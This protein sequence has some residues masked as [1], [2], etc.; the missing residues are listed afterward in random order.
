METRDIVVKGARVHNLVGV[1]VTLPDRELICLTGVSGSGKSSLAFDTIYAEGQRRYVE[2][3]SAYARQFLGQME[4][5]DVDQISGLSPTISIEQKSAGRNPRSTVGTMTEIYDYLRV[6]FARVGAPHCASCGEPIGA[7]TRDGIV[8]R[9]LESYEGE[10]VLLLA[11]VVEGRKGEYQDLF[12]DLQRQGYIRVRVDGRVVLLTEV[13]ALERHIRHDVD[14]VVDRLAIKSETRPRLGEAVDGA[15][16]LSG[17]TLVIQSEGRDD[18]LVSV[19][20]SCPSCG[21]SASPPTPQ[22]FSFNSPQGMCAT[23][24]GLGTHVR[25]DESLVVPDPTLSVGQ[26]AIAPLGIP[27]NRWKMHYYEGVLGRHRADL[28]T[29]WAKIPTKGRRE[30]LYGVRGSIDLAWKRR[31]GSV[32]RHRGRFEGILPPLETRYAESGSTAV[33]R[34]LGAFMLEGPCGECEGSRLKAEARSVLLDGRSLPDV[35][36]M[37]IDEAR[38]FFDGLDLGEKQVTIAEDALKEIHARLTFLLDV[39]LDYLS[40]GRTAPT[41]SGGEAQR[42]RLA[43]QIG[44]GL[45]G[46]TYVLDEPSIGLHHRDNGRLLDAL[47]RLRDT[48]NRVVIVEHDEDTMRRADRILDFGPGPGHLGGKVVAEGGWRQIARTKS[49]ITG[50]YLSGRRQ[51]EIPRE[52][53][54]TKKVLTIRGACQNNLKNVTVGIPT[55]VLTCVTG[56]SGSGKSSLINDVLYSALAR[57]LNGAETRPGMYRRIDGMD[58]LDKVIEIDQQPIGR[59]PRSNPATYTGAFSP[60]RALFSELPESRVRGYKPGRFSFNVKG[61]RCEACQ[62]NGANLVEMD[63]LAD[64][65]VSCPVCEGRRFRRETLDAQFK[66]HSI[67]DVLEMEVEEACGLFRDIPAIHRVLSV[68]VD[69]GMG[70]VK[71]G[72]PAPTLSGGEAQRIKLAKELCR[73]NTGKTLYIL[74]EPTTG[75]HFADVQNL[76]NV[77]N[78]LVDLGNTVVVIEHNTDVIKMADWVIDLGPEGGEEGGDVVAVGPPESLVDVEGSHTGEALKH[79]LGPAKP[80]RGGSPQAR[81]KKVRGLSEIEIYGARE[82]NLRGVDAVIP[83]DKMTVISGVSGSGKSSLALDTVFAEGQRRY[84][85][86]LS[87]YARQFLGQMPKPKVDRVVGLSPAISIEQKAASKNPRSTVG[88]VTEVYDYL[89]ALYGLLAEVHC[90]N[91]GCEDARATAQSSSQIVDRLV[92]GGSGERVILLAP[93]RP[94]RGEDYETVISRAQRSGYRRGRLDGDL[95]EL[96]HPPEIDYRQTHQLEV[97]VDRV[98]LK[99]SARKRIGESVE[100]AL[101]MSGGVVVAAFPDRDTESRYSQH[102]SCPSCA[103]SFDL[104]TPQSFSFNNPEGWCPACEGLGTQRGMGQHTLIPD[105][106]RSVADGA[107]VPWGKPHGALLLMLQMVADSVGFSL[108]TA[109]S[110]LDDDAQEALLYGTG[111]VAYEATSGLSFKFKGLFPT[112]ETLVRLSTRFRRAMGEF[113]KD[114]PCPSC[115]G[116]R[117][118]SVSSAARLFGRPLQDLTET[119]IAEL[120]VWFDGLALSERENETAGEVMKEILNRLHFL[121]DVGLGYLTLGRRAPTLSGGEAQRIRLASQIGSGLTGVLYVLDEPT[122]GLHQRDNRRLLDALQRLRDLGN[123]LIVVEHDRDTLETADH[124]L[125]FG[126]GAGSQGGELVASGPPARLPVR[127]GSLTAQYL[128][129]KLSIDVPDRRIGNGKTIDVLGARQNNLKGI[130]VRFPLGTFVCVTG[131]SGSGKSSLINDVLYGALATKVNRVHRAWGDHDEVIGMDQV[132]KVIRID[133][134][135][136]GHSP[137]SNPCTY[138]KVFDRIRKFYSELPDAQV[139]GFKPGHFSFNNR[140]GR[141]D[142]CDGLGVLCVEMHFLPDVWVTCEACDGKRYNRDVLDV[143]YRGHSIAD[144]LDMTIAEASDLFANFP[145]VLRSLKTLVDVGLGYMKMGQASTTLSGGEAQRVKLSREL[146]RP[147]TRRTVYLL[148][149]PTTGLHFADIQKLLEV[150][151]RLVDAGNTVIVIEHNLDVIKTADWVVDLGPEGGAEGGSL[152]AVGT[153]EDLAEVEHS[154]TGRFLSEVLQA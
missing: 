60:I 51:I 119:P 10:R 82:N 139:R 9:I 138:V 120:R 59:T 6:L 94:D 79:A 85:E 48:G 46:V 68:L 63:F 84:V 58:L 89:R 145:G 62:G 105:P 135:P 35:T 14:V 36:G 30:L 143:A 116:T 33:R 7:Q 92:N 22:L 103:Q 26:G 78:R 86:S 106:S 117:L 100:K 31:N 40:L 2:S 136:I 8:D 146:A 126:P 38:V 69:V 144:V 56:V 98:G 52:R 49:S 83:R 87:A 131:V 67:A 128:K 28:N 80:I 150:L 77:L 127:G 114:V 141:C 29:P 122:I 101:D 17:G 90:P 41:L 4:K 54:T 20:Y 72:Q 65:W 13:P 70:Y 99:T 25:M 21:Q 32:Y 112:I 57:D 15:T 111:D 153:P 64:V 125:D 34:K 97:V 104:P 55:G 12:E 42:I 81:R 113:V 16:R 95:F 88:T 149:E 123:T 91:R 24:R 43:S 47:C 129:G 115:R 93:I 73:A 39:G 109:F 75:L 140:R 50:A 107:I 110:A 53:R 3:L 11:P 18:L 37:T 61:G 152:V 5:P 23:C 44:S 134:T 151:N 108:D 124:I 1:D 147:S 142:G 130:N 148:D 118:R 27:R 121:D 19:S 71:L 96:D 74:D 66:N 132:D 133:Q 154:H 45:V 137:R 76:L 102:L